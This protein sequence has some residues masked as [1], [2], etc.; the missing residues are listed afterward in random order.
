MARTGRYKEEDLHKAGVEASRSR[1][2][3]RIIRIRVIMTDASFSPAVASRRAKYD[4]DFRVPTF[5]DAET[6][7]AKYRHGSRT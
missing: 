7:Y 5:L 3:R 6:L 1:V 4:D 2:Q